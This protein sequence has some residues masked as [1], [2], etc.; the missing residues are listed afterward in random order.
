MPTMFT[1]NGDQLELIMP[2][3]EGY[4]LLF[5]GNRSGYLSFNGVGR[6]RTPRLKVEGATYQKGKT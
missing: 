3:L 2:V 5:C 4:K 6:G 1:L